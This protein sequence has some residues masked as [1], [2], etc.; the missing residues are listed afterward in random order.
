VKGFEASPSQCLHTTISYQ[1]KYIINSFV[2]QNGMAAAVT[3]LYPYLQAEARKRKK[4]QL[5]KWFETR[6]TTSVPLDRRKYHE[7]GTGST[8][9]AQGTTILAH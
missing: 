6:E 7:L 3:R 8:I 9:L 4:R 2:Q 1:R 5:R